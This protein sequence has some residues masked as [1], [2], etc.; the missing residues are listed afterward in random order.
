VY[1]CIFIYFYC[2]L[3]KGP[4]SEQKISETNS[5]GRNLGEADGMERK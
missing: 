1:I 4:L 3:L 5:R 2:Q